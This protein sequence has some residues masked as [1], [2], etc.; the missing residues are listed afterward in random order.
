VEKC[1]DYMAAIEKASVN[2]EI[3]DFVKFVTELFEY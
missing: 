3:D 2:H 1:N